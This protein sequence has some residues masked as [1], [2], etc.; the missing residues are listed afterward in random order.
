MVVRRHPL[1]VIPLCTFCVSKAVA[2]ESRA[3]TFEIAAMFS[4]SRNDKDIIAITLCVVSFRAL[5]TRR[6]NLV[7]FCLRLP[8]ST[9]LHLC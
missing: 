4:T 3:L 6:G 8:R 9:A 7:P 1:F 2:W 5:F